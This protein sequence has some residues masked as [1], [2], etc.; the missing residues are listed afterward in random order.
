MAQGRDGEYWRRVSLISYIDQ[1]DVPIHITGTFNDEQTGARGFAHLW[2][3]VRPG[4]P[5]R[6]LQMNGNHDTNVVAREAG[7]SKSVDD[8]GFE[9]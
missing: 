4:I 5:K 9:A 3:R 2:E 7:G 1:I 8:T 6:L